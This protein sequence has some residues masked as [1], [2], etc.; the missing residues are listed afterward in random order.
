MRL[1]FSLLLLSTLTL[2]AQ[3]VDTARIDRLA[4]EMIAAWKIPGIAVAVVKDDKVVLLK[5]YGVREIGTAQPVTPDTLFQIASATKAFTTTAMAMLV[6]DKK[7]SWDDP[8]RKHLDYFRLG[9]PCADSL[10]TLRDIVSHRTGLSRN[11]ELW[12]YGP[13]SREEILRRIGSV[14]LNKPFRST[15][16]YQNI[17]FMAAGEAAASASGMPWDQLLETRIFGPLA[18][19][20]TVIAET[21]WAKAEHASAHRFDDATGVTARADTHDFESLGPAGSIKSSAR[22]MAQWLRFQLANGTI[23][24]K[25]LMSPEALNETKTPQMVLPDTESTRLDNP[26]TNI[27]AYGLGWRIQ[28]YRGELLVSHGGAL[29]RFRA[30]V[31]LLPKHR[32]GFVILS[33]SARGYGVIALRNSLA[34]VLTGEKPRDWNAYYLGREKKEVTDAEKS[35]SERETKRRQGTRPSREIDAYAGIYSSDGYGELRISV[36][37]GALIAR[38]QRLQIPLTHYHFDTFAAV[39][40]EEDIDELVTFRLNAEGD[41]ASFGLF[42]QE[43]KK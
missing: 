2:N 15:Y 34:D 29:N 17:M 19:K 38:W 37:N 43:F 1:A 25:R 36:E 6:E 24:G 11:D 16:Q 20:S 35:K 42:G 33:N 26:E 31:N 32:A 9:D 7:M 22:D 13:W 27:N 8:V 12:D 23:D 41:V 14:K 28:D 5:G 30:Q 10:V 3:P 4:Q 39:V 21:A 18:M 40:P